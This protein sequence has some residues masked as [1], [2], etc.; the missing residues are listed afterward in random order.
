MQ[1][2][3]SREGGL[4][5][6]IVDGGGHAV[7]IVWPGMGG[8]YRSLHKIWLERGASTIRMK[9]ASEAVYYVARGSVTVVDSTS[10]GDAEEGAMV[11]LEPLTDYAFT[12]L[13]DGVELV[14]GPCPPDPS[15]YESLA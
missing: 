12:A 11:F 4:P 5:L 15:L 10:R 6:S 2:L 3:S 14:G 9:H 8:Q 7:A 13:D 1:V